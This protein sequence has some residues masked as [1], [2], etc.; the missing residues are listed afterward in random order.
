MIDRSFNNNR[1]VLHSMVAS[2]VPLPRPSAHST[3]R[4][5][6]DLTSISRST[7]NV[8]LKIE[9]SRPYYRNPLKVRSQPV[10]PFSFVGRG[11]NAYDKK[12]V[13]AVGASGRRLVVHRVSCDRQ[14][15]I[16]SNSSVVV[17]RGGSMS[18]GLVVVRDKSQ[19]S[20]QASKG[21]CARSR[22]KSL[23]DAM[24]DAK[25][26]EVHGRSGQRKLGRIL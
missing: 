7:S 15:S 23:L 12:E 22:V 3:N 20:S 17:N 8:L 13:G 2:R 26:K 1:Y 25:L 11:T 10:H 19:G 5:Q 4:R 14:Y 16:H 9:K 24:K 21:K 6:A 18:R